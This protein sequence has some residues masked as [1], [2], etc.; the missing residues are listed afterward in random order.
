ML[1]L[2]LRT[3]DEACRDLGYSG[4]RTIQ[5]QALTEAESG[6][7]GLVVLATGGGKSAI[8]QSLGLTR[9]GTTVVISPLIALMDDQ[10]KA[11][12]AKGVKA[13]FINSSMTASDKRRAVALLEA[14][15][16]EFVYVSPEKLGG[17]EFNMWM[18]NLHVGLIVID[19]AHCCL[20]W[21]FDFR[22]SY[23]QIG[24]FC[25]KHPKAQVIAFTATATPKDQQDIIKT[26]GLGDDVFRV[27]TNPD[28]ANLEYN[29]VHTDFHYRSP[30]RMGKLVKLIEKHSTG[31]G[32]V[33]TATKKAA[34]ELY[35][36]IQG[37]RVFSRGKTILKY[38]GDLTA[39]ERREASKIF[40]DAKDPFVIATCAFGMGVDRPDIRQVFHYQ[41]PGSLEAY[42]QEVG[43]AGRDGNPAQSYCLYNKGDRHLQEFFLHSEAWTEREYKDLVEKIHK[44]Y[45]LKPEEDSGVYHLRKH[46]LAIQVVKKVWKLAYKPEEM[47]HRPE[48]VNMVN[49]AEA[50]I[51]AKRAMLDKVDTLLSTSCCRREYLLNHFGFKPE[52]RYE[53]C[54]DNCYT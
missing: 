12:K 11:L 53:S 10:V 39:K 26:L 15:D 49:W 28:R 31:P 1:E 51:K 16:L 44:A 47:Y 37:H 21:G 23:T 35:L 3:L 24:S 42:F 27:I 25:V 29:I 2:P 36:I 7:N 43:R 8:Y 17:D 50:Y 30:S 14:G 4:W 52:K 18:D 22:P 13:E 6:R 20:Q 19:E 40:A 34:D 48:W 32:I 54:C 9:K 33:Y 41:P 45:P 46:L 38:H 5:K